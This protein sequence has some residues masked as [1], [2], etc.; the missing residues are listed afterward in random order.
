MSSTVIALAASG[1]TVYAGGS[2]KQVN[3]TIDR[4][5]LAAFD[6]TF[7][8]VKPFSAPISQNGGDA[9]VYALAV[10]DGTVYVG[11]NFTSPRPL[12]AALDATTGA[13]TSGSPSLFGRLVTALGVSGSRVFAA[14]GISS[15]SGVA[16]NHLASIDLT[17]GQAT[18]WDPNVD[19]TVSA[20]AVSG[21]TIYAGGSFTTVNGGTPHKG[22]AAFDATTG[23]MTAAPITDGSVEALA[24]SGSTVYVGGSFHMLGTERRSVVGAFEADTGTVTS[25]GPIAAATQLSAVAVTGPTVYVAGI[26]FTDVSNQVP[27]YLA[28]FEDLPG[29]VEGVLTSFHPSIDSEVSAV[30]LSDS[31]VYAGG[32]FTSVGV[33]TPRHH[34]AAF[35]DIPG[36]VGGVTLWDPDVNDPVLALAVSDPSLYVGGDFT[37]VNGAIP[38][39]R[40]AAIDTGT[41][42]AMSWDPDA[43]G[44]VR[45]IALSPAAGLVVGGDFTTLAGGLMPQPGFAAFALPPGAPI[46][47]QPA[48]ATARRRSASPRPQL[49]EAPQSRP[50]PS[51]AR[52]TGRRRAAPRARSW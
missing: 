27:L 51:P 15:A 19:D 25:F 32:S 38:R 13:V 46:T 24:V 14:G 4:S 8:S 41:G 40:L 44:A 18:A 6:G 45:A 30:A 39:H 12:V 47:P 48:R 28:G 22:L 9:T 31:T 11:G 5:F 17:S 42:Q 35:E 23:T 43:D 49:R 10:S 34:L 20:L 21:S 52:R 3:S 33:G 1:S 37:A 29:L 16:R 26:F 7:G 50:T 36:T 2:F